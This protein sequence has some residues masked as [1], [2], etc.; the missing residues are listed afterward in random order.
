MREAVFDASA[1]VK[2]LL[3]ETGSEG[4]TAAFA[5]HTVHAPDQLDEECASAVWKRFM[6]GELTVDEAKA[7][8][9]EFSRFPI[10]RH[11]YE[12]LLPL[13]FSLALELR[14]PV[15]DCLYLLLALEGGRTLVTADA[16]MR[17]A[18]E[19]MGVR[20]EWVGS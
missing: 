13:A 7:R 16:R 6:R 14:H 12:R 11:P 20:V 19:A 15:Y 17:E 4:A 3:D 8:L 5:S 10:T 1:V 9:E 2:L 18:A